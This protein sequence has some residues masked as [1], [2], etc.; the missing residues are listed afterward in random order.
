MCVRACVRACV[1]VCVCVC[2]LD[3]EG[4]RVFASTA[5]VSAYPVVYL[6]SFCQNYFRQP[7]Y[8]YI[9]QVSKMS[10]AR[11]LVDTHIPNARM[12][13]DVVHPAPALLRYSDV[14]NLS[15]A[16]GV[17]VQHAL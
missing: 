17:F 3:R 14:S 12:L 1:R 15:Q 13:T 8:I 11:S 4:S 2:T 9:I 7:T 10:R 6:T 16:V 5:P